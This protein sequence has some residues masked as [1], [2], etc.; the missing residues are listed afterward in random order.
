MNTARR[1]RLFVFGVVL[2]SIVMYFLVF[3]NRNV[4]KSP[5]EVIHGK[6]QSQPLQLSLKA[7]CTMRC[8]AISE[9]EIKEILINSEV[10]YPKSKVHEKPCPT[11]A[12]EGKT[13]TGKNLSIVFAECDSL[14]KVLS[15]MD[16][17]ISSDTCNCQ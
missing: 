7:Q 8:Y 9:S 10:N 1:I 3:K 17:G 15:A 4:Y 2:G 12:L 16:L 11:Y 5:S 6:L 14:T 13:S